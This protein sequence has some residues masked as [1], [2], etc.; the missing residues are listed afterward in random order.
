MQKVATIPSPAQRAMV[1]TCA[2]AWLPVCGQAHPQ[3]PAGQILAEGHA[4]AGTL[5]N[6]MWMIEP[7][8]VSRLGEK[9]EGLK[10]SRPCAM[11]PRF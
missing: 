10:A 3:L 11:G 2:A 9:K 4:A 1:V 5:P 8:V 6:L 7:L